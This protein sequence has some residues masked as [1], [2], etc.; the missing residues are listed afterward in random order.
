VD[1]SRRILEVDIQRVQQFHR[2]RVH[3][4][5]RQW[6]SLRARR[7]PLCDLSEHFHHRSADDH[8]VW[9]VPRLLHDSHIFNY[10]HDDHDECLRHGQLQV[11]MVNG[12]G[13]MDAA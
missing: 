3:S 8:D 5:N 6:F 9:P 10:E 12:I 2:L 1:S 7:C 4:A 13:D 11:A